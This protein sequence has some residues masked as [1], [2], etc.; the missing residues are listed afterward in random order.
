[1]SPIQSILAAGIHHAS[2]DAGIVTINHEVAV[3]SGYVDG[4]GKRKFESVLL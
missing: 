1:M 2:S 4:G 3:I